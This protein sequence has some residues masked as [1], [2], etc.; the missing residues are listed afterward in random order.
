MNDDPA[1]T[2]LSPERI[3]LAALALIDRDGLGAFSIRK[4]GADLGCTAMSLYHYYPSKGHLID[5]LTDRVMGELLPLPPPELPWRERLRQVAIA[6]RRM[7]LGHPGFFPIIS[8]HR[9]NTP[10][11]LVVLDGLIALVTSGGAS[12]EDGA[13]LFRAIG[14]YLTGAGLDEISGYDRGPTTVTPVA[15]DMM[16]RAFPHV[17]AA[18]PWFVP[19]AREATFL[20]GLDAL[21]DGWGPA[22]RRP[23]SSASEPSSEGSNS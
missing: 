9:L 22:Q 20:A 5:A 15:P 3:E 7:A 19:E 18:A 16:A 1:R 2:P 12:A 11:C 14:Y 23:A 13:R 21:L 17:V 4:L 6:W 10:K 8:T